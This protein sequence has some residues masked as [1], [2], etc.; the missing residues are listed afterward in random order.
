M[1][2][3]FITT[4]IS[5]P[6]TFEKTQMLYMCIDRDIEEYDEIPSTSLVMVDCKNNFTEE[7]KTIINELKIYTIEDLIRNNKI[8]KNDKQRCLKCFGYVRK[9]Y[10]LMGV[11]P[12][13][14][15][16]L[17]QL[18]KY[19]IDIRILPDGIIKYCRSLGEKNV[20]KDFT[21][22]QMGI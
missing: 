3:I 20:E 7:E 13:N 18:E 16:N 21:K 19:A 4:K 1:N 10:E 9:R 15:N 12:F 6:P 17:I 5:I 22:I 11:E 8:S 2:Y 14:G